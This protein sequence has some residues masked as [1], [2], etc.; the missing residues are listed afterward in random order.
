MLAAD[1]QRDVGLGPARPLRADLQQFAHAVGIEYVE[2]ILVDSENDFEAM[3]EFA[4]TFL[5][6]IEPK[7]LAT[8]TSP[9]SMTVQAEAANRPTARMRMMGM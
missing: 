5:P 2:R 6:S 8:P 3:R 9:S 1:R 4:E 7:L